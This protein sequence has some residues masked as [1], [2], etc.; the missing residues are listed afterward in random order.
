[1]ATKNINP[2]FKKYHHMIESVDVEPEGIDVWL[3]RPFVFSVSEASC[4]FMPHELLR[5]KRTLR[6]LQ[7]GQSIN[8]FEMKQQRLTLKNGIGLTR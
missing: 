8:V 4:T 2:I 1:M 5:T 3:K 6:S 7:Y